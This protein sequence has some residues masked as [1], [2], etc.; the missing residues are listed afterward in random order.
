MTTIAVVLATVNLAIVSWR[1]VAAVTDR[2]FVS[3]VWLVITY[4][5][6][7]ML[8]GAINGEF[9]YR[10][11]YTGA[12]VLVTASDLS[13]TYG[14]VLLSNVALAIGDA[15]GRAYF[16]NWLQPTVNLTL[17]DRTTDIFFG[18]YLLVLCAGGAVY[19]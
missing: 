14:F 18:V 1:T 8:A 17:S 11:G 13:R 12:T 16:R 9:V 19:A 3:A 2:R 5:A 15:I 7:L 4:F 6:I 10:I